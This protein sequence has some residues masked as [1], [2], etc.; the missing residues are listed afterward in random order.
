[1][2]DAETRRVIATGSPLSPL[3]ADIIGSLSMQLRWQVGDQIDLRR[4]SAILRAFANRLEVIS[5]P[6][7]FDTRAALLLA[8]YERKL[9]QDKLASKPKRR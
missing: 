2:M 9:T 8:K 1:M 6:R 5:D 3:D 4:I 7:R